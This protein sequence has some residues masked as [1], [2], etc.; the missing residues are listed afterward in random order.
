MQHKDFRVILTELGR[1]DTRLFPL[2]KC[3]S[4]LTMSVQAS[5]FNYSSPRTTLNNVVDYYEFEIGFPSESVEELLPY[6]EDSE[7]P[8]ETVYGWVPFYIIQKII[9][10]NGGM[11]T[12]PEVD[13]KSKF[14]A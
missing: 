4:G 8:T 9:E 6:A 1:P 2:I 7:N 3:K 5:D 10:E 12:S 11:I 14:L 13:D